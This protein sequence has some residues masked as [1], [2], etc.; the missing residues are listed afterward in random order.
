[1]V[2]VLSDPALYTYT[3][4]SVPTVA[5]LRARYRR[6]A[7]GLSPDGS[8]QWLNW[9]L[10][11]SDEGRLVG[12]VQATISADEAELAWLVEPSAQNGG[13]ATEATAAVADWLVT[14]GVTSLSAHIH[15]ENAASA[16]V[17]RRLGL[18]RTTVSKDGEAR[19]ASQAGVAR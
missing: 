5:E 9:M 8:K 14:V 6:Q 18:E 13:L 1:M 3:G 10:R 19:W 11:L 17:A 12:F 7:V 2:G 15:P 16:I 4:G